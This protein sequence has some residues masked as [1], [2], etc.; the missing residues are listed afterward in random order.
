MLLNLPYLVNL[1]D[2]RCRTL[3]AECSAVHRFPW[4]YRP[5]HLVEDKLTFGFLNVHNR[6]GYMNLDQP[7]D[8]VTSQFDFSPELH[9]EICC[10]VIAKYAML[11][12]LGEMK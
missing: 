8:P 7:Y 2:L 4:V 1:A 6:A 12:L 3:R 5:R 10:S 9:G 11:L